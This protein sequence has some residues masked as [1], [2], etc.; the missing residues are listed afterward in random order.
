MVNKCGLDGWCGLCYAGARGKSFHRGHRGY[1][2]RA[3]WSQNG[4]TYEV[5][6]PKVTVGGTGGPSLVPEHGPVGEHKGLCDYL[7]NPKYDDGTAREL[8]TVT[9]F[10][11]GGAK[12]ALN[13]RDNK[14]SLYVTGCDW[15][16]CLQALGEAITN[17]DG[18]WRSWNVGRKKKGP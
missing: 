18:E 9:L 7:T 10:Y 6:K 4:R 11:D 13:D 5:Q 2:E 3:K 1:R 8:S 16:E 14:R 17:G 15:G 12:A